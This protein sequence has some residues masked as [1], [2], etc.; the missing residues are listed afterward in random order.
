MGLRNRTL[1]RCVRACM[2]VHARVCACVCVCVCVWGGGY[3]GRT[4]HALSLRT[5]WTGEKE[6][7]RERERERARARERERVPARAP[8]CA[9]ERPPEHGRGAAAWPIR[10]DRAG[11]QRAHTVRLC[12]DQFDQILS[13]TFKLDLQLVQRG[14]AEFMVRQQ[15]SLHNKLYT[16]NITQLH[17]TKCRCRC[18][19]HP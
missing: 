1:T 10:F 14:V 9:C 5:A 8:H 12:E 2:Q 15:E 13:F 7:E 16:I 4:A 18:A 6:R 11:R 17:N 3:N 19:N